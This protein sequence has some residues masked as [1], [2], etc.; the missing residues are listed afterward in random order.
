MMTPDQAAE[1]LTV[2]CAYDS[3]RPDRAR[4]IAWADA[5]GDLDAD[6]CVNAIRQHYRVSTEWVMPA[7]IR[8]LVRVIREDRRAGS[9]VKA[10]QEAPNVP[11]PGHIRRQF[12]AL[13]E[14]WRSPA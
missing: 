10:L 4:A 14:R 11:M 12:D 13:V 5:L 1:L 2:A 3:R 8:R 7:H 6:D 9:V